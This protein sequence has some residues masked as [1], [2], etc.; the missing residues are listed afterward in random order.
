M[1]DVQL[2]FLI[3]KVDEN[4]RTKTK[5]ERKRKK[6]NWKHTHTHSR[7][8]RTLQNI[9]TTCRNRK[10]FMW[11]EHTGN[12]WG[13]DPIWFV[14]LFFIF[15][16]FPF[17]TSFVFQFVRKCSLAFNVFGFDIMTTSWTY[18]GIEREECVFVCAVCTIL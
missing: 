8:H 2:K 4:E 11:A 5:I 9:I 12:V 3:M 1:Y 10:N 17:T 15:P 18:T 7:S 16:K 13:I 6:N 14:R